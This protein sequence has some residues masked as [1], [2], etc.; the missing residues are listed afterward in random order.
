MQ[1]FTKS[2]VIPIYG[3]QTKIS[4]QKSVFIPKTRK[5]HIYNS[6]TNTFRLARNLNHIRYSK[7]F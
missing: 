1:F 7:S 2:I 3:N 4:I 6:K 5:K